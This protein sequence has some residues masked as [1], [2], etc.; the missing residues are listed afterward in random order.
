M[1][2]KKTNKLYSL[3][4]FLPVRQQKHVFVVYMERRDNGG[5]EKRG[6]GCVGKEVR[7]KEKK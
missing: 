3:C 4:V 6:V 5:G 2:K 1:E 7:V